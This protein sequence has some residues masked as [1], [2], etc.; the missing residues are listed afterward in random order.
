MMLEIQPPKKSSVFLR[1]FV[2]VIESL[3]GMIYI[4]TYFIRNNPKLFI[5]FKEF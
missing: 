2:Q 3:Y 5:R 1:S 4:L